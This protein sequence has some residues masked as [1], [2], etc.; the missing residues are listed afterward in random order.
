MA[1]LDM[2]RRHLEEAARH[3]AELEGK[4]ADQ[5]SMVVSLDRNGQDTSEALRLLENFRGLL[6]QART[7]EALILKR[8]NALPP[9]IA[10]PSRTP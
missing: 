6:D 3:V 8:F 1:D 5:E 2:E 9:M 10:P 7:H 4:I